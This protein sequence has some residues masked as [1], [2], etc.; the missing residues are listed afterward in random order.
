MNAAGALTVPLLR[1]NP[2]PVLFTW[3]VRPATEPAMV[4]RTVGTLVTVAVP[5]GSVYRSPG[6]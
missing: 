5:G 3:P 2:V 6:R 4:T 1:T